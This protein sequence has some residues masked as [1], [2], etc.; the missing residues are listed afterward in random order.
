MDHTTQTVHGPVTIKAPHAVRLVIGGIWWNGDLDAAA[1]TAH[2]Q[3]AGYLITVNIHTGKRTLKR[4]TR[5]YMDQNSVR[6]YGR[7][8]AVITELLPIIPSK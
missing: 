7:R 3:S 2:D 5:T 6:K 4:L 1:Y 8:Q